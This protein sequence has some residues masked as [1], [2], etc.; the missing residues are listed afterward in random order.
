[1]FVFLSELS[2]NPTCDRC[3]M[4]QYDLAVLV[5]WSSC[6]CG[7]PGCSGRAQTRRGG[8]RGVPVVLGG[9]FVIITEKMSN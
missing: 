1:M 5:G 2:G 8:L 9:A 6:L 3:S 7:V 4:I